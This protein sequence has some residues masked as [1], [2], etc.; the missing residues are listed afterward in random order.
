M[1]GPR[2]YMAVNDAAAATGG[3]K[4]WTKAERELRLATEVK[5]ESPKKVMAPK[6][7]TDRTLREEFYKISKLL[8]SLNVGFCETDADYLGWYLTAR[9]EYNDASVYV[10]DALT[11]G[12]A[13]TAKSWAK[14][15]NTFFTEARTCANALGLTIDSRCRLV[16][17]IPQEPEDNPLE[18]LQRRLL[19][20]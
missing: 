3:G 15:R 5:P 1:P 7:L 12:D 17:P 18:A 19:S 8:S 20:G 2:R 14:T 16:A 4:H 10:R 13:K 9:Q 6:W 11:A